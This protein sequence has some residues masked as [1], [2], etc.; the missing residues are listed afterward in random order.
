MRCDAPDCV[1]DAIQHVGIYETCFAVCSL[2][3]VFLILK[4][5]KFQKPY[6]GLDLHFNTDTRKILEVFS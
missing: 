4:G 5:F 2:H 1:E 3:E 6:N